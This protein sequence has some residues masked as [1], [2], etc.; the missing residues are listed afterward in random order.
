ML[1]MT[2]FSRKHR[3]AK[4]VHKR[5]RYTLLDQSPPTLEIEW[6]C[7]DVDGYKIDNVYKPPPTREQSLDL[8]VFPHPCFYAGYF[9]S[10]H[11][12]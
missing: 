10:R 5:L 6:L 1:K 8:P 9:N 12:Y 3:L 11:V 2:T 7:V 4:F